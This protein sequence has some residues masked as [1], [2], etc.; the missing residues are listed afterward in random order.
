MFWVSNSAPW[1]RLPLIAFGVP[2][3][4]VTSADVTPATAIVASRAN[5]TF[6]SVQRRRVTPCVHTTTLVECSV[7]R[8][9]SVAPRN[10]P[11]TTGSA[12]VRWTLSMIAP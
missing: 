12:I 6:V 4:H 9:M 3:H 11:S 10:A 8:A 7:S 1:K 5:P 2:D